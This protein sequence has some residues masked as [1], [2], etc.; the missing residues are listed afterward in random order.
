MPDWTTI[1]RLAEESCAS[2]LAKLNGLPP[3]VSLGAFIHAATRVGPLDHYKRFGG[4]ASAIVERVS[5]A[6]GEQSA[7][8]F[9]RAALGRTISMCTSSGKYHILPPLCAYFHANHLERIARDRDIFADWLELGSDLF[10]KEFGIASLRLYVAGSQLVDYRCS[11]PRSVVF[12][13]G[14][15]KAFPKA[16]IMLRLGGFKPFFQIHTHSFNLDTFN[17]EGWNDCY[18]CCAELYTLHPGCLG[19]FGSSWFYDPALEQVSPRL[20]YLRKIP[21]TGGAHLL[22]VCSDGDAVTNA[23]EKSGTRKRLY[24]EGRYLPKVYMLIWGRKQQTAWARKHPRCAT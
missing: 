7:R 18:R 9:L 3:D 13:E 11:V 16:A 21:L 19:M 4:D 15:A 12:S 2:A 8:A 14:A 6:C 24:E 10:Q 1:G 23:T 5:H 17:E 22:Y 20:G